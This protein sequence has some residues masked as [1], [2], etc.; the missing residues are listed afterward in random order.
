MNKYKNTNHTGLSYISWHE[1]DLCPLSDLYGF[2]RNSSKLV[3]IS[4]INTNPNREYTSYFGYCQPYPKAR[5]VRSISKNCF[6]V[7]PISMYS[8]MMSKS[9]YNLFTISKLR[10]S[11]NTIR[12]YIR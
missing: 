3:K 1:T 11:I 6:H 12:D 2:H 8:R 5:P 4:Y 7:A 10:G 9:I